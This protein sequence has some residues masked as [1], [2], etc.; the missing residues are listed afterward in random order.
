[1]NNGW[2]FPNHSLKVRI[3]ELQSSD[4]TN[5]E[6]IYRSLENAKLRLGGEI[7]PEQAREAAMNAEN[8]FLSAMKEVSEQFEKDKSD[9]GTDGAINRMKDQW[10]QED[11]ENDDIS[12][13]FQ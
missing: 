9:L 3:T 1:M 7:P 11:L 6:D 5:D 2:L 8:D 13:E 10:D 12:G 4:G